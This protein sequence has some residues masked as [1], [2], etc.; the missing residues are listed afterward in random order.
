M[1]VKQNKSHKKAVVITI[2]AALLVAGG[3]FA[4][5]TLWAP[6]KSET[7]S[8]D[9]SKQNSQ[10]DDAKDSDAKTNNTDTKNEVNGDENKT[11]VQYEGDD[12]NTSD[13]L[14]GVISYK[15][16]VGSN[17]VIRT[18][19]NQLISSGTCNLTLSSGQKTVTRTANIMQNPSSSSCEGFDI[20]TSELG[21]GTWNIN[22]KVTGDGKTGTLTD[23]VSL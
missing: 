20:P 11:P 23:S 18:T 6:N 9:K 2:V 4:Y 15:S 12:P 7:D 1:R 21:S 10:V 14:T 17:L 3:V 8:S 22:I 16:V 13:T 19:I 5:F